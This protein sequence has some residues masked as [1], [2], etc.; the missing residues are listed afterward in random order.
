M[1]T[2]RH[3]QVCMS[4]RYVVRRSLHVCMES[5]DDLGVYSRSY[6]R[7]SSEYLWQKA[8]YSTASG[9]RPSSSQRAHPSTRPDS[10]SKTLSSNTSSLVFVNWHVAINKLER[11]LYTAGG[12]YTVTHK[13]NTRQSVKTFQE[14]ERLVSVKKWPCKRGLVHLNGT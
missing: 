3:W 5:C 2:V 7:T 6:V 12:K 11:A 10:K 4:H 14:I 9:C 13:Q 8:S 1:Y